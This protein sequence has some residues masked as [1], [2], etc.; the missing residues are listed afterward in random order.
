[1]GGA[2]STKRGHK[3]KETEQKAIEGFFLAL[4]SS[5][6]PIFSPRSISLCVTSGDNDEHNTG[7]V[8]LHER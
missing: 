1:M 3:K 7:Y 4:L 5:P 6:S 2:R 8:H